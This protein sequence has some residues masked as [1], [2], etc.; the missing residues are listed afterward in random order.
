MAFS[1]SSSSLLQAHTAISCGDDEEAEDNETTNIESEDISTLQQPLECG[2]K[3]VFTGVPVWESH[4][5]K[6]ESSPGGKSQRVINQHG[7]QLV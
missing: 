7:R 4:T 1:L 2:E 3:I 5:T 6:I